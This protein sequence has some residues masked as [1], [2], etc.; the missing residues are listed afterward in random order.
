[1]VA[2]VARRAARV[3]AA[4]RL[5]AEFDQLE[6]AHRNAIQQVERL[7]SDGRALLQRLHAAKNRLAELNRELDSRKT[8]GMFDA[9]FCAAKWPSSATLTPKPG[10]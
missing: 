10:N 2:D 7:D 8:A 9:H 4:L 5:F 1:M 3:E 6:A